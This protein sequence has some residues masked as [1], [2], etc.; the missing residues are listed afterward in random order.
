MKIINFRRIMMMGLILIIS[1]SSYGL[2]QTDSEEKPEKVYRLDKIIVRDH[3]VKDEGLFVTPDATVINVDK[4]QKAGPVQNIRDLLS[5]AMG[6]DVLRSSI[7]PSPTDS[8]YIRGMDQSRFQV[9]L[10]G[11]PMRLMGRSGYIKLDWTTM[12]LDNVETICIRHYPFFDI[13]LGDSLV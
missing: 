6:V 11:R 2:A 12:P 1:V 13:N 5:E 3:P 10:D 7:T 4:F 9:F 8:I